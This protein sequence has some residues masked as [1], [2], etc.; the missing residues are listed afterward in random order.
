MEMG[1]NS[2]IK[3]LSTKQI[4]VLCSLHYIKN[5]MTTCEAIEIKNLK[6]IDVLKISISIASKDCHFILCVLTNINNKLHKIKIEIEICKMYLCL[7][8]V[9]LWIVTG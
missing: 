8:L 6:C 1:I 9:T 5:E 2:L 3:E 4:L 7:Y